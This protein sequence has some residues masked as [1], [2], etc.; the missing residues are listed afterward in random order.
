MSPLKVREEG[1]PVDDDTLVEGCPIDEGT[2]S[3]DSYLP[4]LSFPAKVLG[5]NCLLPSSF[6]PLSRKVVL[7]MKGYC[8]RLSS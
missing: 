5:M 7:W 2:L 3:P 1:R 4:S 6:N 8:G